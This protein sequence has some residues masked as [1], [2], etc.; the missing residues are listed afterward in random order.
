MGLCYSKK[1]FINQNHPN[2]NIKYYHGWIL[3]GKKNGF[4][5]EYTLEDTKLYEG[6]WENDEKSGEG[7][8]YDENEEIIF[9]GS[10]L[11]NKKMVLVFYIKIKIS[12]IKVYGLMIQNTVK[13]NYIIIT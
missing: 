12:Y 8:L 9:M 6:Q 5:I 3:N 11:N 1:T 10:F 7:I 2:T 13:V 4:G